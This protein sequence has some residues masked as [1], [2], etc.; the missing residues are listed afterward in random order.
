MDQAPPI[1]EQKST[2]EGAIVVVA[3]CPLPG[4]SKTRLLPLLGEQGTVTLAKAML[5]DVLATLVN[6]FPKT[7]KIL[8]YAPG[9]KEGRK[10]M[11]Q[12]IIQQELKITSDDIIHLLPVPQGTNLQQ[13]DLGYLLQNALGQAKQLL[14]PSRGGI[15]FL[16]MDSPELPL[17]EI[18]KALQRTDDEATLCP[19]Q[20]GGYGMLCV[21]QA[22]PSKVFNDILWSH[23][24]TA[25]AQMKALTDQ[26]I[27]VRIGRI[28]HDID[29]P[30]DVRQLIQKLR[31][32]QK[33]D[34]RILP[35]FKVLE[36]SS[37]SNPSSIAVEEKN[38]E[39][40]HTRK[41]LKDLGL[42]K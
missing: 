42:L 3:K 40:V 31:S 5:C 8:Y 36:S 25:L 15:V 34:K 27:I 30:E 24:L 38:G 2:V 41:A 21:S 22:C 18:T 32:Q 17:E 11:Q 20:D 6:Y 14:A 1:Q 16:G 29:E 7:I 4:K 26:S 9:T 35:N 13:A 12:H 39:C 19:S 37:I 10:Y 33:E 23:P 28:M